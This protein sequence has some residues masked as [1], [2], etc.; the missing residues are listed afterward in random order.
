MHQSQG[1]Y[2]QDKPGFKWQ[3][4][5]THALTKSADAAAYV[6][7]CQRR[8]AEKLARKLANKP[9]VSDTDWAAFPPATS[10]HAPKM[11]G[12]AKGLDSAVVFKPITDS[13]RL[14]EAASRIPDR[15]VAA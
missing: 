12:L 3:G 2:K 4:K 10:A 13:A 9:I 14:I 7:K 11:A 5:G 15:R 6:A 8:E 1:K